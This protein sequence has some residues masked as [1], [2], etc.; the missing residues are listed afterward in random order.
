MALTAFLCLYR[1]DQ[2]GLRDGDEARYALIAEDMVAGGDPWTMVYE[3]HPYYWKSPGRI[4]LSALTF[5]AFGVNVW[6]VRIWSALAAVATVGLTCLWGRNLYGKA[7]GLLCG[8][9]LATTPGFLHVHGARTGEMDTALALGFMLALYPLTR[10]YRRGDLLLSGLAIAYCG[11]VKHIAFVPIAL[12]LVGVGSLLTGHWREWS[13]REL[14]RAVG[15]LVLVLAP[16]LVVQVVRHPQ[17]LFHGYFDSVVRQTTVDSPDADP[18]QSFY[19]LALLSGAW[20]WFSV[21]LLGLP[22][23]LAAGRRDRRLW[24]PAVGAVVLL[25]VVMAAQRKFPWYVLPVYPFLAL[26]TGALWERR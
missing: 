14:V 15:L 25:G 11:L 2:G 19:P 18:G 22:L 17:E 6:T 24:L 9:A 26:L 13:R 3:G 21:A 7:A 4:W 23:G 5:L 16:W 10:A 8:F 12:F 1:L 20:P